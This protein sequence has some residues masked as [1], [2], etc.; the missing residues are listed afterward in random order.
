MLRVKNEIMYT[1]INI[2][3]VIQ[4]KKNRI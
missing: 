1:K 3:S 2:T 4:E